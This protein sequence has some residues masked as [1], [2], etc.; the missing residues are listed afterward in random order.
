[1]DQAL[2]MQLE[3]I[4][5]PIVFPAFYSWPRTMRGRPSVGTK[6]QLI[7]GPTIAVL[8]VSTA[9]VRLVG[10]LSRQV[11]CLLSP[12]CSVWPVLPVNPLGC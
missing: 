7:V 10:E 2:Q 11:E 3:D 8:M 6:S 5:D 1:M 9:V 12:V 4:A